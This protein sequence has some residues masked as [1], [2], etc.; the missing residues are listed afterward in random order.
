[1]LVCCRERSICLQSADVS[2]SKFWLR[3]ADEPVWL[4]VALASSPG[5]DCSLAG[6]CTD[7][8]KS[9][10]RRA[11]KKHRVFL[12]LSEN[13]NDKLEFISRKSL[14]VKYCVMLEVNVT[15]VLKKF[16]YTEQGDIVIGAHVKVYAIHVPVSNDQLTHIAEKY[17]GRNADVENFRLHLEETSQVR[18][19]YMTKN[20]FIRKCSEYKHDSDEIVAQFDAIESKF[21][22]QARTRLSNRGGEIRIVADERLCNCEDSEH[23]LEILDKFPVSGETLVA[24]VDLPSSDGPSEGALDAVFER[25]HVPL[26]I[27]TD[28]PGLV[29]WARRWDPKRRVLRAEFLLCCKDGARPRVDGCVGMN[30]R[31]KVKRDDEGSPVPLLLITRGMCRPGKLAWDT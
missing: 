26:M 1:M 11:H 19:I 15:H 9:S 3:A 8:V 29:P 12:A 22:Q 27:V 13:S 2:S 4:S 14:P 24:K 28:L 20:D 6:P 17:I 21:F 23:S 16:T 7:H 10:L 18:R 5:L 25:A 31:V 30:A